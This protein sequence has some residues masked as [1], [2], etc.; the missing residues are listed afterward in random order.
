MMNKRDIELRIHS[1]FQVG[2]NKGDG[3]SSLQLPNPRRSRSYYLDQSNVGHPGVFVFR[4][5]QDTI[6][7]CAGGGNC[8][9]LLLSFSLIES[10]GV[11]RMRQRYFVVLDEEADHWNE[12][13]TGVSQIE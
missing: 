8:L 4:V 6:W 9:S 2:F 1:S 10:Y 5:D 13:Q 7:N 12:K 3:V 11:L